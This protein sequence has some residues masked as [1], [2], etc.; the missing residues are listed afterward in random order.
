MANFCAPPG[1]P[2][3]DKTGYFH[4]GGA[5]GPDSIGRMRIPVGETKDVGLAFYIWS[6]KE[7]WVRSRDEGI[8]RIVRATVFN[9]DEKI[10]SIK[11]CDQPNHTYLEA[12]QGERFW[13]TLEVQVTEKGSAM[14][15][16]DPR[17]TV[18]LVVSGPIATVF[19]EGFAE[20]LRH[21]KRANTDIVV[22]RIKANPVNFYT[23]YIDGIAV[24]LWDGLVDLIKGLAS[25]VEL[26]AKYAPYMAAATNPIGATALA[27]WAAY[28]WNFDPKFKEE[29]KQN[30]EWAKSVG[31]AATAV[32]TE[33]KKNPKDVVEKY[34][35]AT[36]DMGVQVGSALAD[37]LDAKVPTASAFD[38]GY[39]AGWIIGRVLFEIIFLIITEGIGDALKGASIAGKASEGMRAAGE[40]A[41][42]VAKVRARLQGVLNRLP[43]LKAFVE[44]L[45]KTKSAAMA[46]EI[47][48][49]VKVV[50]EA[51]QAAAR[52]KKAM[53]A[54]NAL[55]RVGGAVDAAEAAAKAR[56]A[57]EAYEA[58]S[59]AGTLAEARQATSKAKAAADAA[60][61]AAT[62]AKS[63]AERF[64]TSA[65]MNIA[66]ETAGTGGIRA[67]SGNRALDGSQKIVV[68]GKV[69]KSIA[70]QNF[71][72]NL[73]SG[74]DLGLP[75]YERLHLWGP[76]LGDEAAAGI[77]LGPGKINISE[78]ARVEKLLQDLATKAEASGGTV[79]L[80]VTGATHPPG[81]LP[82]Q[83]R[84]HEFL[85]E[86]TYEFK[87]E[88][89]ATKP[90]TGRIRISVGPPP[91]GSV[92][93]LGA[94]VLNSMLKAR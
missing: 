60:E 25:L 37:E 17:L 93:T 47:A 5:G 94:D 18:G 69:L 80:R 10:Y 49:K 75:T 42:V 4:E 79:Q 59:K 67:I 32:V 24:G 44:A 30:A 83:F 22:D 12:G 86:I 26:G 8:A 63:A 56:E 7:V 35:G 73:V 27:G 40:T 90:L 62:K 15:S 64:V 54:A 84:A 2:L 20:G 38:F 43:A 89:P 9:K 76:R 52:A 39:W 50:E 57:M 14:P 45:T 34:L 61:A 55:A 48:E 51:L 36:R 77:W 23:G 41:T 33:L 31:D 87:I 53:E 3:G 19:S 92:Q 72:A 88:G 28:K 66:R 74:S 6:E 85:S 78:Q 1:V 11:A 29:M 68:E 81:T 58:A 82:T 91:N 13:F 46:A 16:S 21:V 70:R 71:E 65:N